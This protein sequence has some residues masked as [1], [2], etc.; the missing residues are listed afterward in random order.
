VT[1]LAPEPA[2]K[3]S[4]PRSRRDS[5]TIRLTVVMFSLYSSPMALLDRATGLLRRAEAELRKIV[6]DAATA[7]D[8]GSV[9]QVTAWARGV[10]EMLRGVSSQGVTAGREST[11]N[12]PS[13]KGQRATP[14]NALAH[15]SPANGYPRFFRQGDRVVRVA[16]SKREKKEYEH[17][18][19]AAVVRALTVSIANKGAD[20]RVFSM[21][22]LLPIRDSEGA[23]VPAY[24]AYA[25]LAF[26]RHVGLIEQHGRQG[27]STDRPAEL[28]S[29]VDA[30]LKDLPERLA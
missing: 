19:P 6:S 11:A 29:K 9:V 15:P 28:W 2:P 7:G 25:G 17:K 5:E 26:L 4:F 30:V 24:Q 23:E 13:R 21:Q 16:W 12:M 14:S 3:N 20:G 18:A 1:F 27:Y 10:S 8:Y 22:E